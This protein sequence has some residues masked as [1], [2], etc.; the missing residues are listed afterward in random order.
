MAQFDLATLKYI[1]MCLPDF[2]FLLFGNPFTTAFQ[3]EIIKLAVH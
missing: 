1:V 2:S 3:R